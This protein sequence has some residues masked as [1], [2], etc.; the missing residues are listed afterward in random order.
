MAKLRFHVGTSAYSVKE[1]KGTFYPKTLPAVEMLDFYGRAFDTVEINST[2][3]AMPK[4]EVLEG[5]AGRVPK[6]FRFA[7]KAP[8]RI[9]HVKRLKDVA[10]AVSHL[11]EVVAVLGPRSGPVLFQLPPN[12]KKDVPRLRAFVDLLPPKCVAAF[13][14]RHVSWF[15][16]ETLALLRERKL[17]VC[18]SEPESGLPEPPAATAD[19]GYL[20]L[21][22]PDYDDAA[23]RQW[24]AFA[25]AQKWRD[26]FVYFK[27]EETG[28]GPR[29]AKRLLELI[30]ESDASA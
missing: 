26:V 17:A 30:A 8:Q 7:V 14:F 12:F 15:D 29:F 1:W 19:W 25:R 23:L 9:T 27:H 11:F 16:D 21:R 2:F 4:P 10:E 13:E 22:L 18:Y 6:S 5:W 24:I 3:R 28:T 20:R